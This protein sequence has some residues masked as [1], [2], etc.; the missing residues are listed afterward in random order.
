MSICTPARPGQARP[1]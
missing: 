1:G